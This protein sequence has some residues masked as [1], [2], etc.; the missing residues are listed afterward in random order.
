MYK[1]M[2]DLTIKMQTA[3]GELNEGDQKVHASNYERKKYWGNNIRHYK[4]CWMLY[5]KESKP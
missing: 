4:Y 1:K 3:G 2:L 5:M